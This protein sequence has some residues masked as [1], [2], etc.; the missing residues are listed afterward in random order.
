M[1]E[2]R[3]FTQEEFDEGIK[4]ALDQGRILG[5]QE[6]QNLAAAIKGQRDEANDKIA[7]MNVTI[8]QLNARIATLESSD[9]E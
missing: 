5:Q 1:T 8:M 7:D 6:M 3:T 9:A 4:K 2:A